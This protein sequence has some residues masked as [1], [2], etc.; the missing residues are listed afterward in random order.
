MCQ[1]WIETDEAGDL[2]DIVRPGRAPRGWKRVLDASDQ[3]G[4]PVELVHADTSSLRR[5]AVFDAIANN[6]DRKG[7][8]VLTGV[9][10]RTWAIDHGVTFSSES[11]LRTVVWGWAGE[12]LGDD[13]LRDVHLLHDTLGDSF[14][15]IDRWL[16]EDERDR[17]RWR[18]RRL[19]ERGVFPEPSGRWPAIPWPV[20]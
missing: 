12:P 15:P 9:D 4:E 10:G 6:A 5:I 2:V 13:L 16:A 7:G 1:A 20:F 3:M 11:K 8:H 18:V 14:D 17:L 19:I